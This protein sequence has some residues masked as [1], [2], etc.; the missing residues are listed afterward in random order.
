MG[1]PPASSSVRGSRIPLGGTL[2]VPEVPACWPRP[3]SGLAASGAVLLPRGPGPN[4]VHPLG[5][6]K[7]P[8]T[9]LFRADAWFLG[10][11]VRASWT[12]Q[13]R[14]PLVVLKQ[15]GIGASAVAGRLV[16]TGSRD[17]E[18]GLEGTPLRHPRASRGAHGGCRHSSSFAQ[19]GFC[20]LSSTRQGSDSHLPGGCPVWRS[21]VATFKGELAPR[22]GRPG[23]LSPPS[24]ACPQPSGCLPAPGVKKQ[25]DGHQVRL[26]PGAGSRRGRR[27]QS[28]LSCLLR[29][30]RP[31]PSG[32]SA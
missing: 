17:T 7:P 2:G 12:L 25:R 9:L 1:V 19:L 24:G 13:R 21:P 10:P 4:P 28:K 18:N 26:A 15:R 16:P 32:P 20:S 3:G 31:A 23:D 11:A 14:G 29:Q 30:G 6:C 27:A 5:T 8:E 22:R